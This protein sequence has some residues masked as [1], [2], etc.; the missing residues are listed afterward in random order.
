MDMDNLTKYEFIAEAFRIDTGMMAPGKDV[1]AALSSDDFHQRMSAWT[2]WRRD[3]Q[4]I[5][6]AFELS[7]NHI[8]MDLLEDE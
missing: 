8:L 2:K 1:P 3:N 6:R 5:I 7:A 4:G